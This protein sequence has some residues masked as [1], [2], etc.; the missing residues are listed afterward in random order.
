MAY[1]RHCGNQLD[2]RAYV[3][4]KCGYAVE[5]TKPMNTDDKKSGGFAFLCFLFPIVGLILY[6]VWKDDKPLKAKS[7]A[8]GAIIGVVAYVVLSILSVVLTFLGLGLFAVGAGTAYEQ[9][10][11]EELNYLIMNSFI[12]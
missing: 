11:F 9:E 8:K 10:A 7:C 12:K 1:C 4:L 6:L 2:E 5:D 3:C